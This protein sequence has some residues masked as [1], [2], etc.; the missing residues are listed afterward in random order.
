[1]SVLQ[2]IDMTIEEFTENCRYKSIMDMSI[3]AFTEN[4]SVDDIMAD[5][6]FAY[7]SMFYEIDGAINIIKYAREKAKEYFDKY[8][9]KYM[10]ERINIIMDIVAEDEMRENPEYEDECSD[11]D[12]D[13]GE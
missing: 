6:Y 7:I 8:G 12:T 13:E 2:I 5:I 3:E 4:F 1:M 9:E 11:D 10:I